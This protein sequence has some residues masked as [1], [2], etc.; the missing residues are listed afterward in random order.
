NSGRG[1]AH[2]VRLTSVTANNGRPAQVTGR[3]PNRFPVPIAAVLA[4]DA[5]AVIQLFASNSAPL[6]ISVSAD[7]GRTTAAANTR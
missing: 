2:D 3:D 7:G 4:P 5:S 6:A 1:V